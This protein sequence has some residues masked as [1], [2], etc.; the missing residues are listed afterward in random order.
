LQI[1]KDDKRRLIFKQFLYKR[2]L[3]FSELECSTQIR[4]NELAY[5]LQKL[6][7]EQILTKEE[8]KYTLTKEAEKYIPFFVDD[9]KPSPL[10]V[11]LVAVHDNKT[12]KYLLIYRKKRPYKDH[13]GLV[14]GRIKFD[15]SIEQAAVRNIKTKTFLDVEFTSINA[16]VHET[17]REESDIKQGLILFFVFTTPLT[18]IKEKED[19]KW[20]TLDEIK[21]LK[22]IPSDKWLFLNKLHSRVDVLSETIIES[23][24]SL[25]ME[26]NKN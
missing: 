7:S 5:F 11:V 6:I 8:T 13:W 21:Q 18:K 23:N 14:G 24:E 25:S 4:S 22:I 12:D 9:N 15:E 17:Y 20:F 26:K 16:V 1:P 2:S 19:L 3:K 10:P